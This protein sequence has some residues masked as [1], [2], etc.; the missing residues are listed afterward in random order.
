MYAKLKRL[1]GQRLKALERSSQKRQGSKPWRD[2][3]RKP[4]DGHP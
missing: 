2:K 3:K 4:P 1:I